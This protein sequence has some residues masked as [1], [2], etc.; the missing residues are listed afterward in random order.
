MGAGSHFDAIVVGSGFGGSVTAYRL[1]S[2]GHR[3][4][5]LERGKPYPPGSFPRDPRGLARSVWDPSEGLHGMFDI[6]SFK[7]IEAVVSSGL[8]GGSLIYANV[9]IRK[10]E[11]WFVDERPGEPS[12]EWPVTRATLDPHYD[13]V[14]TMLGATPFPHGVDGYT[15]S[16][17]DA[18]R[19]AAARLGLEWQ[20]P[21]LAI[22]FAADGDGP[23]AGVPL[24]QADYGNLHG[25]PRRTCISCG[26]CDI[27][28]NEGAK[29]TL[30]HT[31]LSAAAHHGAEIRT[32]CEVRRLS[33]RPD[34]GFS[35]GYV[36]HDP[37]NEGLRTATRE[38]PLVEVGADRLIMAAGALGTP[39]L[40]LRNRRAFPRLGP[41]L[42][43][44]FCG[45][46][47]LLGFLS[48]AT[49]ADGRP[50]ALDASSAPVI[51]SAIRMPDA[52]EGGPGRGFYIQDAG[53]PA[54]A[55]WLLEAS[56]APGAARRALH[57]AL[58]RVWAR[59]RRDPRSNLG[60][61]LAGL[62]ADGTRSSSAMPLLG[63]GR[64][65][66]DGTMSLRRGYLA[67]DWTIDS[68]ADYFASVR[69]TMRGIAREL[70]ARFDDNPTY[71][72][73]RVVTVHP[74]G[75]APMGRHLGEGVVDEYGRSFAY[76]GLYVVDGAALPGP[77]GPNPAL[78]IAAFADRASDHLLA[79]APSS[80][81]AG[82][83]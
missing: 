60:A 25:R 1:A 19:D 13:A 80:D 58:R 75:G 48:A 27:G 9:L 18:M 63:M 65:V 73:R 11:R 79:R 45:N 22:S 30:D 40:L 42:G 21:N 72:L 66:P 34:G 23:R 70:G 36:E 51:T 15:P 6:W 39:Y 41:A 64:D 59:L 2:A 17:T 50:R 76:P 29:N 61:A 56:G 82:V 47:D 57:F 38:L 16:K 10:D 20:L 74:L 77:V 28:C 32:R 5:V 35:V 52:R 71:A 62:L 8:G 78:T 3:V 31:Y 46:G 7:G 4:C 81:G 67:V 37:A 55:D 33:P 68:S 49:A 43:T 24:P 53:Y 12:W 83:R 44:R 26:E 14:E 54:F 69:E